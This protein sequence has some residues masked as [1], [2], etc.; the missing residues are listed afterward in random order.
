METAWCF[1]KRS[2][3]GRKFCEKVE[4]TA[5]HMKRGSTAEKGVA[6]M[7]ELAKYLLDMLEA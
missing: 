7:L 4:A 3:T 1:D 2:H 6:E 5:R